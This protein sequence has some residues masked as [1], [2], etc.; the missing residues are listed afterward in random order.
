VSESDRSAIQTTTPKPRRKWRRRALWFLVI[1]PLGLIAA[2]LII[3]QTSVMQVIVEPILE[4]QMGVDVSTGSVRLSATGEIV[5]VDAVCEASRIDSAAGSLIE[6]KRATIS[7]NWWG[8]IKGSGQVR[9]IVIE[10]PIVRVSQDIETGVLNLAAMEF[11]QGGS[12]GATPAIEITNGIFEIGEHDQGSY[13]VLKE[14]SFKG[15]LS[16]QTS[17]GIS[18]FDFIALPKGARAMGMGS[19]EYIEHAVHGS[20]G[21]TGQ[22]SKDGID[23]V[24]DGVRLEDWPADIVPSRSRG[25]YEQLDLAG[26]LAPTRFHVSQDG[27]VEIVLMLD[28]VALNLPIEEADASRGGGGDAQ[29]LRMRQTRGV[30][31]FGTSGLNA[32][33]KGLI[34][35]LEY[36]VML[37]Y[38]GLEATS[39]FDAMLVTD[40]RLDE[41][42][43]PAR[44]L[45]ANVMSKLDRFEN[46]IADVHATV[47]ISRGAGRDARIAVSGKAELSN[48]SAIYKKF[49]YLFH[50]LTGVIEFDP[51]QLVIRDIIGVGPTGARLVANGVFSPLG[52]QSVVNLMLNV[53]G[54]A[55]DPYLI[56]ALDGDQRDLVDA[57]FSETDY[58]RLLKDGLV[59]T[60]A[61]AEDLRDTRRGVWDRLDGWMSGVDGTDDDRRMLAEELARLDRRL[62]APVFDFGAVAD[63]DVELVRHPERASDN[64]WTTDVRVKLAEAGLVSEHFPLPIMAHDI[65]ILINEKRVELLGGRY[66]GLT[67]GKADLGVKV[68]LTKRK[69]KPTITIEASG[70]PIDARL[71]AAIPGYNE[72]QSDDPDDISL[73]RILDRLG[74]TG[75]LECDA[76][77]GPRPDGRLGYDIETTVLAGAARPGLLT[78]GVDD[79]SAMNISDDPIALDDIYGTVYITE[80]LIIVDLDAML[81]TPEQPLAPTPIGVLSQLTLINKSKG[82]G[83]AK[84]TGGMLPDEFGPPVPGP[85]LYARVRGE[86]I[87]LAMPLEHAVAVIA[88]RVARD[89]LKRKAQYNP[90][91]FLGLSAEFSGIVGGAIKTTIAIDRVDQFGFDIE[92]ARYQIGSSWGRGEIVLAEEPVVAF[93]GFRVSILADGV[94]AGVLSLDGTM[95]L[96]R[97]GRS[98]EVS[99]S[100]ALSLRFEDGTFD[101]P[102]AKG[103]ID[104][105]ANAKGESW[106]DSHEIGGRF[107]LDVTLTPKLGLHRENG[108]TDRAVGFVPTRINGSLEPKSLTLR[109]GERS[110]Q[111]DEL[112]GV[113]RF[114]GFDGTIEK[115]KASNESVS[116]EVSGGWSVDQRDGVDIDLFADA[117]GDLLSESIRMLLPEPIDSVIDRLEIQSDEPMRIENLRYTARSLGKPSAEYQLQGDAK[118]IDARA[119]VGLPITGINGNLKF[120]ADG[121]GD[122]VGYSLHLDASGLRAGLMRMDDA[123]VQIIGDAN[124]PGVVLIPEISASMHGG[125]IAGSAQIRSGIDGNP[126]YWME[127]HASGVRVAPVFDDLLLPEGLEGPPRE[128]QSMVRSVWNQGDDRSRGILIADLTLTGP[129]GDPTKRSGRGL[130]RVSGGSVVALPGLIQLI[131]ASNLSMP[132]GSPLD[133]AQASFYVDGQTLAFEQISAS[134]KRIEILGYGTL[135]W[136]TRALDLRFRSRAVHPIPVISS[137]IEQL[138]DELI[139]TRV[140]GLL[141][142]PKYSVEQFGSTMRLFNAMLGNA[143]SDLQRRMREVEDQV[144]AS[145]MRT[146]ENKA[147]RVHY[148]VDEQNE[149]QASGWE[150]ADEVSGDEK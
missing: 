4:D 100:S 78:P 125:Q 50:D 33:I 69:A 21:L 147:Q 113:V 28:G 19:G 72:P 89:L 8:V 5:I 7:V 143:E 44:F 74:L 56:D 90:D 55:I 106:F 110:A 49:R 2:V 112:G 16:R 117:D 144:R 102:I 88:P 120:A 31:R 101:S 149:T 96:V 38:Q 119:L 145:R 116:L 128:G 108:S 85:T 141:G 22:I 52:E 132:A 123:H 29:M 140:T 42:F 80:E 84:R 24:L 10:Q 62:L 133:M 59:L 20:I 138:R 17:D 94:D 12:G 48:G 51:D 98:I 9:S 127:L 126:N 107:D 95:P 121:G 36:D 118:L 60:K 75:V 26:D 91:G 63:V 43:K 18:G 71:V 3:G 64:R 45:P 92:G 37:D 82:P 130:A 136:A 129:I 77:I 142:E 11:K 104:R 83:G 99:E 32:D 70:F 30:I 6:F 105:L 65:E 27:L 87:D 124:N 15:Q 68:D 81:S 97:A 103:V 79:L 34:D 131:E 122:A 57:L 46:P 111:F 135:D 134:S 53:K 61:D 150:W 114:A 139:T 25:L 115:L 73:R 146:L 66:T 23:G 67:G 54:V 109:M 39:P 13:R 86:K 41:A 35:E 47:H 137:I 14:F 76:I 148:P 40:F 58:A 93:D 1:G